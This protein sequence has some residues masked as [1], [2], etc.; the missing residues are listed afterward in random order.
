MRCVR[1]HA[2]V[3][4]CVCYAVSKHVIYSVCCHS[5]LSQCSLVPQALVEKGGK[6][7]E[8][9]VKEACL[10]QSMWLVAEQKSASTTCVDGP[11]QKPEDLESE[12]LDEFMDVINQKERERNAQ[13][14]PGEYIHNLLVQNSS[15]I[16]CRQ[17]AHRGLEQHGIAGDLGRE[18]SGM[19]VAESNCAEDGAGNKRCAR[20]ATFMF[21]GGVFKTNTT[22]CIASALAGDI[23]R[24]TI[25]SSNDRNIPHA[26]TVDYSYPSSLPYTHARTHARRHTPQHAHAQ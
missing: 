24:P 1:G 15:R 21:K 22:I 8:R 3:Y 23:W 4:V 11:T 18:R 20:I 13:R 2:F 17:P 9:A 16:P 14:K 6:K 26:E 12:D 10:A 7:I 25:E 5:N 19:P